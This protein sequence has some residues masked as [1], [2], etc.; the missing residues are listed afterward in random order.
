M[1][2]SDETYLGRVVLEGVEVITLVAIVNIF[3]SL[4]FFA[5]GNI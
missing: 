4:Y 1:G 2:A 3:N 5:L